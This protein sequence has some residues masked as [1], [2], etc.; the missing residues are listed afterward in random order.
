MD[1]DASCLQVSLACLR[2]FSTT[3][4]FAVCLDSWPDAES[5]GGASESSPEHSDSC[6]RAIGIAVIHNGSSFSPPGPGSGPSPAGCGS[7]RGAQPRET[8]HVGD[9]G[10]PAGMLAPD[11]DSGSL[12]GVSNTCVQ[13]CSFVQSLNEQ[14]RASGDHTSGWT[15]RIFAVLFPGTPAVNAILATIYISGP[16]SESTAA[17]LLGRNS[18]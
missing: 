13:K 2:T 17:G 11:S 4:T 12:E 6:D 8:Q 1:D 9:R 3:E 10:W 15:S 5:S 16:P 14:K 18:Y 7:G